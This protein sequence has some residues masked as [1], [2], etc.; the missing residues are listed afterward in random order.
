MK[1]RRTIITALLLVATL[2]LGIG[3]AALSA[4]NLNITG[5][6]KVNAA[7]E[8]FVVD[9]SETVVASEGA[10]G[11]RTGLRAAD[12]IVDGLKDPDEVATVTYTI[13]NDAAA[14]SLYAAKIKTI[15]V[16]ADASG[17]FKI[18]VVDEST[19]E[20]TILQ[21]G[22]TKDVTVKVTLKGLTDSVHC[23]N[24]NITFT[25]DPLMPTTGE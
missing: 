2:A 12:I 10:S 23:S 19:I 20:G 24:I 25:V 22:E 21:P 13:V 11:A 3:Y 17:V 14:G 1:K 16:G 9:F 4:I 6:A 8:N 7:Q 15:D 5:T 18:E